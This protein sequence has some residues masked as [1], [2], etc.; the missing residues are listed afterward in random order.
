[1]RG[2]TNQ[3]RITSNP[4]SRMKL[5]WQNLAE[6]TALIKLGWNISELAKLTHRL[7]AVLINFERIAQGRFRFKADLVSL[8][9]FRKDEYFVVIPEIRT[10]FAHLNHNPEDVIEHAPF[11]I[12][13][14]LTEFFF[15]TKG[16]AK[17]SMVSYMIGHLRQPDNIARAIN[18]LQIFYK[19]SGIPLYKKHF[20]ALFGKAASQGCEFIAMHKMSFILLEPYSVPRRHFEEIAEKTLQE[21]SHVA[22]EI[23]FDEKEL[24]TWEIIARFAALSVL[25]KKCG[26]YDLA[27]KCQSTLQGNVGREL[28]LDAIIPYALTYTFPIPP[29]LQV[30]IGIQSF[31]LLFMLF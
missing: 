31:D 22:E 23:N 28:A 2:I 16:P 7:Q 9:P 3:I 20:A 8:P 26:C 14:E 15:N 27:H 19:N 4:R 18:T 1:M 21:L 10:A 24:D 30:G 13:R 5:P 17:S 29:Q 12:S 11:G 25:A 6:N